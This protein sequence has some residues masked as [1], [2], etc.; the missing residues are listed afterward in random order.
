[1][2]FSHLHYLPLPAPFY[3]A[4]GVHLL[5]LAVMLQIGALRYVCMRLG[6][7]SGAALLV[8]AGSLIGSYFN[9]PVAELPERNIVSGQEIVFYGMQ[10]VVP[11]VVQWP[12]TIIAVNVGGALIPALMSLYLLA[13]E[14]LW[15]RGL[16]AIVLVAV[17]CHFLARPVP[18]LGIAL[19]VF[20]P[21]LSTAV[22]ALMLSPR[23]AAPLAYI[24]GSVGT[25]VGADL[26]NM[27]HVQGLGAPIASIGGA[28]TFDG[29]FLTGILAVLIASLTGWIGERDHG[30][31]A[32]TA[33]PLPR[34]HEGEP[35]R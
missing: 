26:L 14:R 3:A 9:I 2:P 1:M 16:V 25:L 33:L 7:S 27:G 23:Y 12:G 10:Y 5:I 19:P 35:P 17:V 34:P 18:G 28:G 30:H 29:I 21:A 8:L 11:V 20:V 13:R 32:E 22:V 31:L 24:G 6:M 15:G 4:F